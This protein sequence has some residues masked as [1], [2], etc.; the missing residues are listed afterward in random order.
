MF[1][2][3]TALAALAFVAFTALP[4]FAQQAAPAAPAAVAQRLRGTIDALNGNVLSITSRDGSKIDVKLADNW[5]VQA[6]FAVKPDEIKDGDFVGAV[7]TKRADGVMV[8][9]AIQ[10]LD[11]AIRERAQGDTAWDLTP[12]SLMINADLA[13]V[14]K[15]NGGIFTVKLTHNKATYDLLIAPNT[16]IQRYAPGEKSQVVKGAAVF[17]N[18][19][20][21]PDGTYT[22]TTVRA[23]TN[24]VKPAV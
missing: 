4:A 9:Q 17:I 21:Q 20:K 8:A 24:G 1:K 11:P 7:A 16:P 19:Q 2:K 18:A 12:E 10:V 3:T 6:V 14:V 23:E 15:N 13:Q 5:A 22:A